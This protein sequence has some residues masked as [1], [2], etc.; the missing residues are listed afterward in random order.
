M[1]N[2]S[3]SVTL[4]SSFRNYW[5]FMIYKMFLDPEE[6]LNRALHNV[7][8]C[9][10]VPRHEYNR[11]LTAYGETFG[12][13]PKKSKPY[14]ACPAMKNWHRLRAGLDHNGW[15]MYQYSQL[16]LTRLYVINAGSAGTNTYPYSWLRRQFQ[17]QINRKF[18]LSSMQENKFYSKRQ[19]IVLS[20]NPHCISGYTSKYMVVM[21]GRVNYVSDKQKISG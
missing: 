16:K 1:I 3:P 19:F 5:M 9:I 15:E 12:K 10:I 7:S 4:C 11:V 2:H 17:Y 18:A 8:I 20:Q 21:Y 14:A 13:L 6:F